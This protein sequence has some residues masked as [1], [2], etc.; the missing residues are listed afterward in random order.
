MTPF[1]PAAVGLALLPLAMPLPA[2][3][4]PADLAF[5]TLILITLRDVRGRFPPF[6]WLDW[7]VLSYLATSLLSLALSPSPDGAEAF[8]KQMYLAGVYV[9]F[10]CI[11]ARGDA[12]RTVRWGAAA[13]VAAAACGLTGTALFFITNGR[14]SVFGEA[15]ALPYLGRVFRLR[16]LFETPEM[17]VE[18]M[19]FAVPLLLALSERGRSEA[20]RWRLGA[21]A[22]GAAAVLT[23]G[24]GL[25]GLCA[26]ALYERWHSLG[27]LRRPIGLLVG[28]GVLAMNLALAASVRR[29]DLDHGIDATVGPA[30]HPYGAQEPGFGAPRITVAVT[31]D[32]MSYALLKAVA[33]DAFRA[34]PWTGVGLGRFPTAAAAAHRAGSLPARYRNSRP[35]STWL[36]RLA[37]TGVIG[38][39]AQVVL[40]GC[41][42][43]ALSTWEAGGC[44]WFERALLAGLLSI[45]INS[46]NVDAMNFRFVWVALG[47]VRGRM[48]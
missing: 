29:V 27:A 41:I 7:A 31:Y 6:R 35:H 38:A 5:S 47:L 1:A 15:M 48:P 43:A 24:R 14:A 19:A 33:W 13:A 17:F 10:A 25:P 18:Y 2:G 36:G 39:V 40:W 12:D 37:E 28:L 22:G 26:G 21:L 30:H 4:Q 3:L 23:F 20:R 34:A 16:G 45:F 11:A 42:L 32:P 9:A 8:A 46:L 44:A